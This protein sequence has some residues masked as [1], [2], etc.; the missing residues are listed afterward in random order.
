MKVHWSGLILIGLGLLILLIGSFFRAGGFLV[1]LIYGLPFLVIGIIV[2]L[3]KKEDKIE[4]IQY[5]E[6]KNNVRK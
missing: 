2:L 4:E 3:N 1:S 6:V 5:K